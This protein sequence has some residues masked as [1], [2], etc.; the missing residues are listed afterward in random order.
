[1]YRLREK[2]QLGGWTWDMEPGL[3]E[4]ISRSR[5]PNNVHR[6]SHPVSRRVPIS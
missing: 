3:K 6:V 4:P 2:S 1:M 5:I